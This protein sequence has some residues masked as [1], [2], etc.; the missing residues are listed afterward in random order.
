MRLNVSNLIT[1]ARCMWGAMFDRAFSKS[2]SVRNLSSF[3][4]GRESSVPFSDLGR[5]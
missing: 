2:C 4:S 5:P 1:G 3:P